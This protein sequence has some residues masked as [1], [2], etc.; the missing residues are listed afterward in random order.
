LWVVGETSQKEL[1]RRV[2]IGERLHVTRRLVIAAVELLGRYF[3]PE[4]RWQVLVVKDALHYG[5]H[6]GNDA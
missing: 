3:V 1:E 5:H 6:L 4:R 2:R